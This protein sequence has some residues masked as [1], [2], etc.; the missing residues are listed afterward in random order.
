MIFDATRDRAVI[1]RL[2][3]AL[4][5]HLPDVDVPDVEVEPARRERLA[6][7]AALTAKWNETTNLIGAK[8]PEAVAEV[9]FADALL[10]MDER[11]LPN[12]ARFVDVGAGA[13]APALPLL[14]LR[15]D[16]HATLVE[17][18]RLRVAFLRTA[19]A[20]LGLEERVTLVE[21][22]LGSATLE[23]PFDA[24]MSRATF[25]P[26]KWLQKGRA[27][28]DRV[29]VL[30]GAAGLPPGEWAHVV[31]YALPFGGAPRTLGVTG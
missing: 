23:T 21:A 4:G 9:L 28:S 30:A 20:T 15:D 26:D 11:V 31:E 27:L 5:V 17:P 12:G 3:E 13:G 8:T 2:I 16:L 10:L 25:P 18:R 22:K 29:I 1:D 19:A 14:L 6:A 24:A 7:F